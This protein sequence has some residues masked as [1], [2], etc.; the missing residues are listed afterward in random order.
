MGDVESLPAPR[1]IVCT[2]RWKSGRQAA[3][4]CIS[5]IVLIYT[6]LVTNRLLILRERVLE[7]RPA[8][9]LW[10]RGQSRRVVPVLR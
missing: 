1:Y 6:T 9:R 7:M 4:M 10:G 2:L 8:Y 5:N 3:S